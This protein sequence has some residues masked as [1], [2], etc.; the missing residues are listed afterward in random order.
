MIKSLE[1]IEARIDSAH[2]LL[3]ATHDYVK[4]QAPTDV[5]HMD[6][7][8]IHLV[9]YEAMR[10][11]IRMTQIIGWLLLQKAVLAEELSREEML[12]EECRILRGDYCL[13]DFSEEN[14]ELPLRL[15]ELLRESR[16][17]YV[18]VLR[19]DEGARKV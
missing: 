15:R 5:G 19:L 17:L 7:E 16:K 1:F 9:T 13:E 12:S 2:N 6:S 10:I 18:C 14:E 4:W 11:T 8:H 3:H